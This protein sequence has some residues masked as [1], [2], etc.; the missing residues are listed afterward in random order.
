MGDQEIESVLH[1][2]SGL[3]NKLTGSFLFAFDQVGKDDRQVVDVGLN[4]KNFTK[5]V[6]I[7][8]YVRFV[9]PQNA[10]NTGHD[11]YNHNQHA[12]GA[13]HVRKHWEYSYECFDIIREY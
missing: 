9:A 6:H 2:S 3:I 13:R 5:K 1:L 8:D 12:R 7:P 4:I 10:S 11:S